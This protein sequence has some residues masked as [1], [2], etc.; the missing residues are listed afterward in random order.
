MNEKISKGLIC[1]VGYNRIDCLVRLLSN[2]SKMDLMGQ[3]V[4]LVVSIDYSIQQDNVFSEICNF[5]WKGGGFKILLQNTNLGLKAHVLKCAALVDGYDFIVLLEDDLII[6]PYAFSFIYPA[7]NMSL[8]S[9]EI[10]GVSLYSY[11]KNEEDKTAFLPLI[12]SADNYFLQYPSSWGFCVTAKQWNK[13]KEWLDKHDSDFFEDSQVPIYVTKWPQSSWKKHFIRYLVNQNLYFIYP[14]HSLTTN[15]GVDGTHHNNIKSL[16][17]VPICTEKRQWHLKPFDE[18]FCIYDVNFEAT[19]DVKALNFINDHS[20]SLG[21]RTRINKV[22]STLEQS[23][24]N[25]KELVL[26][27][28]YFFKIQYEKVKYKIL[29]K[30]NR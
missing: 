19:T 20:N 27:N 13:F 8:Q 26:L 18:S 30:F 5:N 17:S 16:Y 23:H 1:I 21:S 3:N 12:D 22:Q 24:L 7:I 15:P 10:A 6:S 9:R 29:K 11:S 4:D 14:R 25:V 2:V 28:F